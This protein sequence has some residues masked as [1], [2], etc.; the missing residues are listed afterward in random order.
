ML[1]IGIF[2][3]LCVPFLFLPQICLGYACLESTALGERL[4]GFQNQSSRSQYEV[5]LHWPSNPWDAHMVAC[6]EH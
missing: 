3:A 6:E 5:D 4:D 2:K 1:L